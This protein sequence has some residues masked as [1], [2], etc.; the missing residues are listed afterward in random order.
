MR[1]TSLISKGQH[2]LEMQFQNGESSSNVALWTF[3]WQSDWPDDLVG[4]EDEG[5]EGDD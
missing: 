2:Q 1:S 5:Y 4:V 3:D